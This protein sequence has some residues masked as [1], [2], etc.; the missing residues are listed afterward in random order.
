[1]M[2]TTLTLIAAIVLLA[3]C[4]RYDKTPSGLAYKITSGGNKEKL[5][6]GQFV[7]LN[8]EYKVPPK[9]ST[10]SSSYGHIP[11]Y[12]AVDTNRPSKHSFF[13]ILTKCAV[14]DKAEFAMSVDTL[15]KMGVLE[16]NALFHPRDVIKGRF[17]ILKTFAK[18]EDAMADMTKE[19]DAEKAREIK[20][21]QD[22]TAKKGAKT[23]STKSG[24]LV[25]INAPGDANNRPDS[26]KMA[27]VLYK[28]TFLNGKIFD[29]NTDK[30]NPS[31]QPLQVTIGSGG[32]IPGMDEALQLFGK[33]SKGKMYIPAMLAYGQGGRPPVIP[34]YSNLVFEIEMLD[35]TVP[36][37]PQKQPA[38]MQ[39]NPHAQPPQAQKK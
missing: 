12:I 27:V 29:S 11:F 39:G 35:V 14:G 20:E 2:R 5:K 34:A 22:F 8:V 3:G 16:Y 31:S 9:D 7:K 10:L 15:K 19:Q 24:V 23:Q 21:L 25:E 33:G 32:V 30:N 36:P 18:Q 38:E 26:G 13:E 1:M 17:E 28:G 4:N 37:P 6:H